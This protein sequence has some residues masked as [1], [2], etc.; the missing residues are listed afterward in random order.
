L[1]ERADSLETNTIAM[2][3]QYKQLRV[4]NNTL[5]KLNGLVMEK[6]LTL[7]NQLDQLENK[8][9]VL[10][11]AAK[12]NSIEFSS[13][14]DEDIQELLT[15]SIKRSRKNKEDGSDTFNRAKKQSSVESAKSSSFSIITPLNLTYIIQYN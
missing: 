12:D 4:R 3:S 11:K 9:K 1:K 2:E 10:E 13:K 8:V 14:Q 15:K 6:K 7:R 5:Q